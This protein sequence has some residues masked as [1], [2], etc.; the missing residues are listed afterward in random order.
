MLPSST[1]GFDRID[2]FLARYANVIDAAVFQALVDVAP[3]VEVDAQGTST[4]NDDTGAT[5]AS[6]H[7]YAHDNN[8]VPDSVYEAMQRAEDLRP[9]S[10]SYE[11]VPEND[12]I[13][14]DIVCLTVMSAT[15]YSYFLNIRQGGASMYLEEALLFNLDYIMGSVQRMIDARVEQLGLSTNPGGLNT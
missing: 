10:T 4:Y 15:E 5:R 13:P 2:D 8:L 3:T 9:D 1:S 12:T 6:T 11:S 14:D 7:A